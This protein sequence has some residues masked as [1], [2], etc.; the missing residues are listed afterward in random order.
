MSLPTEVTE[1]IRLFSESCEK[2]EKQRA[3]TASTV[4]NGQYNQQIDQA[5]LGLQAQV[6][7]NEAN[8]SMVFSLQNHSYN[9]GGRD[10]SDG[11]N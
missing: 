7:S 9:H 10:Y 4:D 6:E 11:Y 1:K 2:F 3:Q 5:L 8:L